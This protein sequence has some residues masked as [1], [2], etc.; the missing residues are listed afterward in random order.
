MIVYSIPIGS[1][2]S[3]NNSGFLP[4]LRLTAEENDIVAKDGC[5]LVLGRS[6]TGKTSCTAMRIS[7]DVKFG[8]DRQVGQ[9]DESSN[10]V[11][12]LTNRS[13]YY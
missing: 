5:Q 13:T 8:T 11:M 12:A 4:D 7:R 1:L 2:D 9:L 10:T 6:G 3:L